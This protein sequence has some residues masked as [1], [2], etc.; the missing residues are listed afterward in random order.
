MQ[1]RENWQKD[2]LEKHDLMTQMSLEQRSDV[3]E[4]NGKP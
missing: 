1:K 2:G 4:C 3:Q